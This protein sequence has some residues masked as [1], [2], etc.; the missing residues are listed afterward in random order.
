MA[1][2]SYLLHVRKRLKDVYVLSSL[3]PLVPVGNDY[4]YYSILSTFK[5][6]ATTFGCCNRSFLARK[7]LATFKIRDFLAPISESENE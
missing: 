3:G 5:Y 7:R 4:Y 2:F 6:F 1:I